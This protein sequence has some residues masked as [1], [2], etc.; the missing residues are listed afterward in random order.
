MGRISSASARK[1][2][3]I[4][5]LAVAVILFI[6]LMRQGERENSQEF[7]REISPVYGSI[8]SLTSTTGEV[9]PQNRLEIK[10][11]IGGRVEKILVKEGEKVKTGDILALMSSTERAALLDAAHLKSE[12]ELKYWKKVYNATPLIAPIDGE[13]I[14]RAVEPGQ[15]VVATDA[16]I[17]LSDRLIV[18]A[19]VD[20]TD[21]GKVKVGRKAIVSLDAY[22]E[23]KVEAT[24]DHVSYESTVVNNVTIYEVDLLPETIPDV[25][26]SGMSANVEVITESKENVLLIPLKATTKDKDEN[27]VLLKQGNGGIVKQRVRLGLSDD[28]NVE[29][30]SGLST[31]DT[32]II[33]TK[34]YL[35]RESKESGG[36]PF[37]P[38][39]DK[40]KK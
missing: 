5:L 18:K 25:F 32:V 14:V 27:F 4:G 38:K 13:V 29:V 2:I 23:I 7:A 19:D 1:K 12:E 6:F 22:P 11:P 33:T 9:K 17:V 36:N 40:K 3:Y 24:V 8:R 37:M 10:P 26:R 16:I 20:E 15:T 30:V 39:F 34:E 35:P 28:E 31:S 21:I